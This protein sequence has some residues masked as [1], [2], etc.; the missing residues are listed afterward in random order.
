MSAAGTVT[1]LLTS[2]Y[3]ADINATPNNMPT[4]YNIKLALSSSQSLVLTDRLVIEIWANRTGSG[5]N[6][7]LRTFFQNN[8]YSFTQTTLNSGTTLLTSNN[9]AN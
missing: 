8:Y 1:T 7:T 2:P 5:T 6:I 3:S 4:A 9:N